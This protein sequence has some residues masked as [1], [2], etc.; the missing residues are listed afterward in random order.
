MDLSGR[1]LGCG[2]HQK[3]LIPENKDFV[4][5]DVENKRVNRRMGLI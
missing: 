3:K 1:D 2:R 5:P 4:Y